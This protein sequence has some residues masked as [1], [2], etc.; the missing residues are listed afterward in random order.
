M[1]GLKPSTLGTPMSALG[2]K[3]TSRGLIA[4][5]AYPPES[6]HSWIGGFEQREVMGL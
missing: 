2:H 1:Q 5:S 4:M 3:Q 6:V